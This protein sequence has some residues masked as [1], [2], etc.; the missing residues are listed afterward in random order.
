MK[1]T[2]LSELKTFLLDNPNCDN[3]ELEDLIN[4]ARTFKVDK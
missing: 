3:D 1:E 2:F 4:V